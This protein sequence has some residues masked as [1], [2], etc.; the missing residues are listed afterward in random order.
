MSKIL[1]CTHSLCLP[2]DAYGPI[3]FDDVDDD[4]VFDEQVST[5]LSGS[6]YTQSKTVMKI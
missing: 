1:S 2:S 3:D 6:F 4:D 5:V